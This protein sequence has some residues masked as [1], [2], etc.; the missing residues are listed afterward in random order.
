MAIDYNGA[1]L[2]ADVVRKGI[3][4]N[5]VIT[6]GHLDLLLS[7]AT[8]EDIYQRAGM[9]NTSLRCS[10]D[11]DSRFADGFLKGLGATRVTP[12]D[13]SAYE[14]AAL[15][16]DLNTP[17]PDG[18][19]NSCDTLID[20]GSLEHIF[21]APMALQNYIDF[22]R[23]GGHII[24]FTAAN[25][26]F[27]HGFYQFSPEIFFRL[28]TAQ[29]GMEVRWV[30]VYEMTRNSPMYQVLDPA[31]VGFRS[32]LVTSLPTYLFVVAKKNATLPPSSS[33]PQQADYKEKWQSH[34]AGDGKPV[35]EVGNR[36][37]GLMKLARQLP[38]W[39]Q[40]LIHRWFTIKWQYRRTF[41]SG[42]CFK[43]YYLFR[44]QP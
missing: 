25:N 8:P 27:G 31:I 21:N 29:N 24:I 33:W 35:P 30:I 20:G 5:N 28:F 4:L 36:G 13:A 11:Q 43:R 37:G 23:P 3:S 9:N 40:R 10:G 44:D 17:L 15:L 18:Y 39:L 1:L 22:V 34:A 16:H 32:E 7:P 2:L 26:Q 41:D 12:L 42:P 6:V 14:G 19:K 38:Y